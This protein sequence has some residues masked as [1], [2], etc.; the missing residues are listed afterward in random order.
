MNNTGFKI[1]LIFI[2]SWFLQFGSRFPILG[3]I[4]I[5]LLLV[6]VLF[7][8]LLIKPKHSIP[9]PKTKIDLLLR[10]LIAYSIIVIPFVEW[11][12]SV[13]NSGIEKLV[14]AVVFYYFTISFIDTKEKLKKFILVFIGCQL[15]RILEPLY[16]NITQ[17]YWG[18]MASMANW[19]QLNRLSGAPSDIINPNGLAFVICTTLPFLYY[20]ATL[21]K[22]N[23]LV[24]IIFAPMC[25]YALV[26]TGSRTGFIGLIIISVAILMK[27]KN[28][29][30]FSTIGIIIVIGGFPLLDNDL[31]DRFLSIFG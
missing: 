1:Y 11:P 7:I 2:V 30:L 5:S 29:I 4:R 19:E 9:E 18:S 17:G 12:G 27:S 14:K 26:L 21:N 16:L 23:K 25:I 28:R 15:F 24:F 13:I 31:Q 10:W 6:L 22:I 3:S 8:L 20:S